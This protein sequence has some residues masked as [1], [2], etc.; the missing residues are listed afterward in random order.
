MK[1]ALLSRTLHKWLGLFVG[2]QLV[3][4]TVSGFYMVVV[5]LDFIHGDPLVRNLRT[6]VAVEQAKVSFAY[7]ARSHPD[8][9]QISLRALP[10]YSAPVYEMTVGAGKVL[11]DAI[12]GKQ[13]SPL[14]SDMIQ[15]LAKSYYAGKGTLR[16]ATLLRG[17]PPLEI[18]TRPLP[19]WR[20]D[21]DDWLE[22]SLYIHPDTG[23]LVTRRHRFWRWFDFLWMLHIMDYEQRTDMNNVLLRATTVVGLIAVS[24]GIWLLCF[25]FRRR[26]TRAALS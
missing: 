8:A 11:F 7:I 24:S 14:T 20:A 22:T 2:I 13:L 10:D 4:W 1:P 25:S 23:T 3:L 26:R 21:F 19:L 9:T 17:T 6:P 18:Q 16:S 12:D 5:D 15:A